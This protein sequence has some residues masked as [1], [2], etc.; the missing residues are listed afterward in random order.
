VD[1]LAAEGYVALAPSLYADGATTASI[2]EAEMLVAAHKR[3]P[4]E[5]EAV[6]QAAVAR[7]RG[8][9]SVADA[10]IGV[11]GASWALHLSRVRPDDLS[12]VVA[13][14]GTDDGDYSTA[15]AAYL[16]HFAEQDDFEPLEAVRATERHLGHPATGSRLPDDV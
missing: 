16:G 6:V 15:R 2:A 5:A 14:Y 3:A 11:I 9:P 12:A 1:R 13:A 8:L 7:L 10:P 4:A